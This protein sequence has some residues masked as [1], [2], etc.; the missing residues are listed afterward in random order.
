MNFMKELYMQEYEKL[1]SEAVEAGLPIDED[2]LADLADKRS[3]D[4]F[5]NM[6]D[7]ARDRAKY[8]EKPKEA[9]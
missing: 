2:M 5:A 1:Y 3:V 8:A 4:R 6:C 9:I 7:Q